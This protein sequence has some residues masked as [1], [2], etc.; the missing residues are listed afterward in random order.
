MAVG[1]ELFRWCATTNRKKKKQ[2]DAR[3]ELGISCCVQRVTNFEQGTQEC[4]SIDA[5]RVDWC[6]VGPQHRRISP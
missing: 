6:F 4:I 3:K 2:K 5:E 1:I